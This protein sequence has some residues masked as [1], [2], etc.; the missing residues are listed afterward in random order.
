MD[1]RSIGIIL[2]TRPLTETSLIVH[3]LTPN[4][5]RLTTVAK[6]ARRP[7]STFRGKVDIFY[8]AEFSFLRSHRSELH[9]LKEVSLLET[10]EALRHELSYLQQAAYASTLLEQTTE[11]ETPL[12]G[13]FQLF[14][15]FLSHLKTEPPRSRTVFAFEMKLLN[16]LGL[17][18]NMDEARLSLGAKQILEKCL[19][20]DWTAL[21]HLK[22]TP[23][24]TTEIRQFLHGFL[25]YHLGKIPRGRSDALPD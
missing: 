14:R 24:Q 10:N 12:L 17:N 25:I 13:L 5:G 19:K 2:R 18:P 11:T 16:E 1:E 6:G 7:K 9:I 23:I 3:W 21:T 8:I 4:L 15:E 22:L 20:I